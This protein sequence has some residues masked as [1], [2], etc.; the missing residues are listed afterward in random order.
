MKKLHQF[1]QGDVYLREIKDTPE[2]D[3]S[4]KRYALRVPPT[5][6]RAREAVAWTFGMKERE[7]QP[8]KES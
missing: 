1:R 7:Y 5:I 8:L 3:G 2:P 4:T 6:T